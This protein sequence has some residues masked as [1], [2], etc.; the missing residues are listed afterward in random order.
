MNYD[1]AS[2]AV[3]LLLVSHLVSTMRCAGLNL[4]LHE[5][6]AWCSHPSREQEQSLNALCAGH[7]SFPSRNGKPDNIRRYAPQVQP[8]WLARVP[9]ACEAQVCRSQGPWPSGVHSAVLLSAPEFCL[10]RPNFVPQD[11]APSHVTHSASASTCCAEH[12]LGQAMLSIRDTRKTL[13]ELRKQDFVSVQEVPKRADRNVKHSFFLWHVN[14]PAVLRS[15]RNQ[16]QQVSASRQLACA[17][18]V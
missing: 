9:I 8:S 7:V 15:I 17:L 2:L 1:R 3:L 18:F 16:C 10:L 5:I 13:Y 11:V 12:I 4:L 14:M 6:A